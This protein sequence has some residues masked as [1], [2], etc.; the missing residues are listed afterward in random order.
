MMITFPKAKINL[1]LRIT[2]KRQDGY[3]DIETLFYPVNLSDALEFVISSGKTS[4]DE[5]VVTGL[6]IDSRPENNIVL[7]TIRLLRKDFPIPFLKIHLHKAIPSGAG[8]GGGSSDAS[9]AIKAIN[10]YFGFG[11]NDQEMCT[12][13]LELGSDCPFFID[14]APSFATGRGEILH[15][16]YPFLD[17]YCISIL[18][19]GVSISTREAYINCHPAKP[20]AP[21]EK[22]IGLPA[23]KW[24]KLVKNDFEEYAFKLYPVISDMKKAL[25]RSGAIYSSMS[26]SGSSVFGIYREKPKIPVKL[27]KYTIYEGVL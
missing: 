23:D 2:A 25:Y 20:E 17:G 18:N 15:P 22:L 9:F 8:L 26:G 7:K 16:A 12:L 5:L 13:A 1:G 14:P 11:L 19:P 4:C 21:L 24:K 27:K 3:H 6:K 10:K